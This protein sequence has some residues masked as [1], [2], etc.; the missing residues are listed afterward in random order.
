MPGRRMDPAVEFSRRVKTD[1]LGAEVMIDLKRGAA[2]I[3]KRGHVMLVA[4]NDLVRREGHVLGRERRTQPVDIPHGG[5]FVVDQ[6][7]AKGD[8]GA[9]GPDAERFGFVGPGVGDLDLQ[10]QILDQRERTGEGWRSRRWR[11]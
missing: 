7:A 10:R 3:A 11:G 2:A 1:G 6:L 8:F 9:V 5:Q 4:G